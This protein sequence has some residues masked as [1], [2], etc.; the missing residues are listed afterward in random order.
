MEWKE[1]EKEHPP[2]EDPVLVDPDT[3]TD[4]IWAAMFKCE[5]EGW[6]WATLDSWGAVLTDPDGYVWDGN[7]EITHWMPLPKTPNQ[8]RKEDQ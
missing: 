2:Y 1:F 5:E 3:R 7:H 8:L 6:G 4:T